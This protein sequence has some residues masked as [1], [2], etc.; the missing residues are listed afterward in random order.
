MIMKPR[1][2]FTSPVR[3][4]WDWTLSEL[5]KKEKESGKFGRPAGLG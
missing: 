1:E 4:A 3:Q 2:E 5:K